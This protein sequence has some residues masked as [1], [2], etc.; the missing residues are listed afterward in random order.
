MIPRLEIRDGQCYLL[1]EVGPF[2]P[3]EGKLVLDV[4][5]AHIERLNLELQL[6]LRER[7]RHDT[8]H[9]SD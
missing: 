6:V 5:N 1:M 3:D 8:T 7:R 2:R 9:H 4:A